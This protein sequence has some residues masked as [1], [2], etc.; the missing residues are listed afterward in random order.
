MLGLALS[1]KPQSPVDQRLERVQRELL[2]VGADLATAGTRG[3][4][5]IATTHIQ[6]LEGEIDEMER[7]L[8]PLKRFILP[9]GTEVSATLHTART[10][11]R[12]AERRVAPL[13]RAGRCSPDVVAYLNRLS[14]WLFVTA[15]YSNR[16]EGGSD[17]LWKGTPEDE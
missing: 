9:G 17:I 7:E 12:R 4:S 11:C 5:R 16:R 6:R 15:R 2:D 13:I 1:L 8:P 14:D 10:I 3:G